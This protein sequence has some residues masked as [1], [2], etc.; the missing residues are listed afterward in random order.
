MHQSVIDFGTKHLTSEVVFDARVLEIGSFNVNGSLRPHVMKLSPASYIGIDLQPGDGVD[1]I[2]DAC[3][4]ED[5]VLGSIGTHDLVISTEMLEHARDWRAAVETM[6][7]MV[8]P[9]GAI[10]LTTRSLGFARHYEHPGD[11]WRFSVEQMREIFSDFEIAALEPDPGGSGGGPGVFLLARK[12]I[13]YAPNN[14]LALEVS[15][16]E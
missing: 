9:G 7:R 13:G 6:K 3:N 4:P 11:Y 5:A 10:L 14:L 15:P 2:A 1:L 8:G 12:P 16:V